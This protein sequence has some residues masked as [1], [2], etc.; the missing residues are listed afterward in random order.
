MATWFIDVVE[1]IAR[2][3]V[4][5]VDGGGDTFAGDTLPATQ[6]KEENGDED[7]FGSAPGS[8]ALRSSL[9]YAADISVQAL[10]PPGP[11]FHLRTPLFLL[12]L[13]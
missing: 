7:L 10:P 12:F 1:K 4:L 8:N 3:C 11:K 2:E 5:Q 6:V 9:I 13:C